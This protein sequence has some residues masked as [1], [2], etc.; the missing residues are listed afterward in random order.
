MRNLRDLIRRRSAPPERIELH[1]V[2]EQSLA[3]VRAQV[4]M[5]AIAITLRSASSL[6]L[7]QAER[8]RIQ[9]VLINLLRNA[10]DA[11]EAMPAHRRQIAINL[12][13]APDPQG[14]LQVLVSVRDRGGGIPA[15]IQA[16]LFNAFTTSKPGGLG[17]GLSICR[18]IVEAY[19][20]RL[21]LESTGPEG[22]EFC[23]TLPAANAKMTK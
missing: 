17:L 11:V 23:F 8:I 21:W 16:N 18:G 22:S 4:R 9:Q 12:T 14:E 13:P 2:V 15:D 19:A 1:E 6:P 20:G 7:I 3:L 5:S 10:I